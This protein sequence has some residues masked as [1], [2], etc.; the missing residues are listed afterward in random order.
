MTSI[1][2]KHS[3]DCEG[4]CLAGAE[5]HFVMRDGS[6][7]CNNCYYPV[8]LA[9]GV[10]DRCPGCKFPVSKYTVDER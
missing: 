5:V 6:W 9:E 7:Y 4:E 8:Y 3:P 1:T 2:H 10:P